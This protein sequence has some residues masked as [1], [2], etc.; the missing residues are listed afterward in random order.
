MTQPQ[1]NAGSC[2]PNESFQASNP[3]CVGR[4]QTGSR[5]IRFS[6]VFNRSANGSNRCNLAYARQ[7]GC[8]ILIGDDNTKYVDAVV[9]D[10]LRR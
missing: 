4:V 3:T 9:T 2:E 7:V 6:H 8:T 10:G 1:S 5:G